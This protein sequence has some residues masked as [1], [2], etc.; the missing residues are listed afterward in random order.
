MDG[1]VLLQQGQRHLRLPAPVAAHRGAARRVGL[2]GRRGLR[3]GR[4]ARPGRRRW[5]P[6]STWRC[7]RSSGW[8]DAAVVA[9][10]RDGHARR[11][12]SSTAP[13]TRVLA[14]VGPVARQ[15]YD[16]DA[17]RL[18]RAPRPGPRRR[19]RDCVGAAQ[20]RRR[21]CRSTSPTAGRWPWSASSRARPA[22]RAPAARRSTRPASTRRSTS[23]GPP[24]RRASRS[25]SPRASASTGPR[26]RRRR[27]A[28]RRGRRERRGGRRRRCSSSACPPRDE[29]EGFDRDHMDLPAGAARPAA[30]GRGGQPTGSWWCSR[31]ARRC[32]PRRGRTARRRDPGGLAARPGRRRRGGRPAARRRST[33][34]RPARRDDPAAARGQPAVPE[35]PRRLGARALR[36]G[37]LRRLPRARPPRPA[38]VASRSA[39]ACPTRPS[40]TTTWPSRSRAATPTA[41]SACG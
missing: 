11:G 1:D 5:P 27:P 37:D 16:G 29:S 35:L 22:S 8:S 39:T 15:P 14:L 13:S 19:P 2:R 41:T 31:T 6:V 28:R 40:S 7:R 10:V 26:R 9:A 12:R 18:R 17:G 20:E 38:G 33:R 30:P 24:Y 3:L 36:R 4:G 34:Q 21:C 25:P 23:C 32:S